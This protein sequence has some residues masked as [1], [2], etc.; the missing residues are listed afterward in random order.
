M[1]KYRVLI[2][3]DRLNNLET[4]KKSNFILVSTLW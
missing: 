2:I 3:D 4:A 1:N